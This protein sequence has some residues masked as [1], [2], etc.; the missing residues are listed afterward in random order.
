MKWLRALRVREGGWDA[1]PG[2]GS[3]AAHGSARCTG[4]TGDLAGNGCAHGRRRSGRADGGGDSRLPRPR[5]R[6]V[7]RPPRVHFAEPRA[8]ANHYRS[9][10]P[11]PAGDGPPPE[12]HADRAGPHRAGKRISGF[13]RI[14]AGAPG[15][16]GRG[17]TVRAGRR[18]GGPGGGD[19]RRGLDAGDAGGAGPRS[20]AGGPV[21]PA[22][23]GKRLPGGGPGADRPPRHVVGHSRGQD[24]QSAASRVSVSHGLRSRPARDRLRGAE[25][26]RGGGLVRAREHAPERAD[27]GG[28]LRGGRPDRALQRG[29]RRAHR[30]RAG[31]RL[32]PAA[33][34]GVAGADLPRR[35]GIAAGVRRRRNRRTDRAAHAG[36][37]GG[38]GPGNLRTSAGDA[39][40]GGG[41]PRWECSAHRRRPPWSGRPPGRGSIS[42]N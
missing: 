13:L 21:R 16:N 3:L 8:L 29:H 36:H 22:A 30:R 41:R 19:S 20:G 18:A 38:A 9:R 34:A 5:N 35:V 14:L 23:G 10:R 12:W 40:S 24:D 25:S 39:K 33:R 42:P 17:I 15:R 26:A 32:F 7:A 11:P 37:R 28:G 31:E 6:C 1:H 4:V 2:Y 27:H